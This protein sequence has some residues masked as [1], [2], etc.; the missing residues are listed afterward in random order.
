M[1]PLPRKKVQLERKVFVLVRITLQL[2][3]KETKDFA[4]TNRKKGAE[5][6]TV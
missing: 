6:K 1:F 4:D 5:A 2:L 3:E